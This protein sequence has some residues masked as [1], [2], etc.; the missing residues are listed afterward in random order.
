MNS[1][2]RDDS[3]AVD[4]PNQPP[5]ADN[6][7]LYES[8]SE[9]GSINIY[10]T[11]PYKR[12]RAAYNA[13]A[14]LEYLI[15]LTIIDSFLA[16]LGKTLGISDALI[17]IC[18]AMT[19]LAGLT[20]IF[21]VFF[22]HQKPKKMLILRLHLINQLMFACLYF[23]PFIN[24]SQ[25][26]TTVLF[27]LLLLGGYLCANITSS[28]RYTLAMSSVERHKYGSFSTTKEMI[29]LVGGMIFEYILGCVSD[30]YRE[31]EEELICYLLFGITI[32][33]IAILHAISVY[34]LRE[35][36]H[37][38]TEKAENETLGS[39]LREM[40]SLLKN[41]SFLAV[42]AVFVLWRIADYLVYPFMG[43]YAIDT[44]NGLG[45]SL[46]VTSVIAIIGNVLRFLLSRPIG[47]F[48]DRTS[49]CIML[50]PIFFIG[51]SAT[52]F[53]MISAPDREWAYIVYKILRCVAYTGISSGTLN[54]VLE[55]V[56]PDKMDYATALNHCIIGVTGFVSSLVG[57]AIL[58]YIQSNGNTIFGIHIYAQQFLA[59]V[60]AIIILILCLYMLFVVRKMKRTL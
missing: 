6:A 4:T 18:T 39:R 34:L 28:I 35:D 17:G 14:L 24:I 42:V 53:A 32:I 49:Y 15:S 47:K 27:V 22:N 50:I 51:F 54:L 37:E 23:L 12:S 30:Y 57:S 58:S 13:E 33:V 60:S 1:L 11:A 38:P 44:E 52:V 48:A 2:K 31:R 7:D 43:T 25:S 56:K 19:S 59:A 46:T 20:Q 40:F 21:T 3:N 55:Y 36:K 10:D 9:E 8:D 5:D 26:L 41:R 45:Y 29:S 16:A